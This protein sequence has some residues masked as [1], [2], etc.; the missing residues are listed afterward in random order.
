MIAGGEATSTYARDTVFSAVMLILN[1]IV[2]LSLVPVAFE[3]WR[4]RRAPRDE[5][6][7]ED[8]ERAAVTESVRRD[9]A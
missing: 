9:E 7:D 8:H 5:R 2:G 4:A 6:Y 3:V 1:G